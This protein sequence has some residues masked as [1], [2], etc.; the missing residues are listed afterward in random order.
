MASCI[1]RSI[2][3]FRPDRCRIPRKLARSARAGLPQFSPAVRQQFDI[4]PLA[5]FDAEMVEHRL[6][7]RYLSFR[8]HRQLHP[9]SAPSSKGH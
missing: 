2:T 5:K 3:G 7:Q 4:D 6:P 8:R 1:S 9:H